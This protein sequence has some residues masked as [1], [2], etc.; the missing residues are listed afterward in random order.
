MKD[1]APVVPGELA[2]C[3]VVAAGELG[4]SDRKTVA[5]ADAMIRART[6]TGSEIYEITEREYDH[7]GR[8][9]LRGANADA[10]DGRYAYLTRQEYPTALNRWG[11]KEEHYAFRV[12]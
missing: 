5:V 7:N 12:I 1:A 8:R 2:A 9:P 6:L 4:A 11:T 10:V 3:P